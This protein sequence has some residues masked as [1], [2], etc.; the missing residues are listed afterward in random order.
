MITRHEYNMMVRGKTGD[1]LVNALLS[2]FDK[3]RG[4]VVPP[5]LSLLTPARP[6]CTECQEALIHNQREGMMVCSSCGAVN[7]AYDGATAYQSRDNY[8]STINMH[9][10]KR[11]TRFREVLRQLEGTAGGIFLPRHGRWWPWR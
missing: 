7:A 10:Y 9:Q 11:L 3:L 8:S 6:I 4:R 2:N 1:D 5:P